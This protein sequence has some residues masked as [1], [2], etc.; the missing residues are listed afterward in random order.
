MEQ[1]N[2]MSIP[3]RVLARNVKRPFAML[4]VA[5]FAIGLAGELCAAP[6]DVGGRLQVLWD[7]HV[8]DAEM[9]NFDVL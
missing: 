8:V 5:F 7:D 2:E 1:N 4:V 6:I 9:V 3:N